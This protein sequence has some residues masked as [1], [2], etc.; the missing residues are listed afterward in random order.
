MAIATTPAS[1]SSVP[2]S[3]GRPAVARMPIGLVPTRRGTSRTTCRRRWSCG[4]RRT[5]W[6]THRIPGWCVRRRTHWTAA[7]CRPESSARQRHGCPI[8][9]SRGTATATNSRS[10]RRAMARA[11]TASA[12]RLSVIIRTSRLRSNRRA[13][14]FR[15]PSA[16]SSGPRATAD[17]LLATRLTTRK[18]PSATQLWGSA[19]VNV[20]TGGRKKKLSASIAATEVATATRSRDVAATSRT[21]SR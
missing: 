20:P 12:S 16:S 7:V 4:D 14:S 1:V 21:T 9:S 5:F 13:S 10:N 8:R 15:R 2:G 3:T 19:M 11:S 17:R 6:H 18:A